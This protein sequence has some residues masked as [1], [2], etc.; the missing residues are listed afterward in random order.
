MFD[1]RLLA[2]SLATLAALMF[3]GLQIIRGDAD[4]AALARGEAPRIELSVM[5]KPLPAQQPIKV[6]VW[7]AP[8]AELALQLIPFLDIVNDTRMEVAAVSVA[9][10]AA[11]TT[12]AKP[13]A[14]AIV[15][16][17]V[18]ADTKSDPLF[19]AAATAAAR[20]P[21]PVAVKLQP[22]AKPEPIKAVVAPPPPVQAE[23][24]GVLAKLNEADLE[25]TGSIALPETVAAPLPRAAPEPARPVVRQQPV[26]RQAARP[27]STPAPATPQ[28][29]AMEPYPSQSSA[30]TQQPQASP[31]TQQAPPNPLAVLFPPLTPLHAQQAATRPQ[32]QPLFPAPAPAQPVKYPPLDRT[33]VGVLNACCIPRHLG[34]GD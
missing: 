10:P 33:A 19:V 32:P 9:K 4:V 22:I 5:E 29:L 2:G 26:I 25:S 7:S 14:P 30:Q 34:G 12:I 16:A 18:E 11:P 17:D 28:P 31:Q 20:E 21:A 3:V 1:F 13:P 8:P 6:P 24:P 15:T 27:A 23:P